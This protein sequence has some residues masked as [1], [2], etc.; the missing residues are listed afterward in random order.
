VKLCLVTDRRRLVPS[1]TSIGEARRCLLEQARYAVE[2]RMDLIQL[3]ERDLSSADLTSLAKELLAITRGSETRVVINDRIDVALVCRADGVHLR[4]DS[5]TV[6]EARR[7]VPASFLIGRSIHG[8]S[9]ATAAADAD[10]LV[11]G[12]VFPSVSK[13]RVGA[14]IGL[15]G[16]EAIVRA[17]SIP[18]LAIGGVTVDRAADVGRAGASG[19]AAIGLFIGAGRQT[20]S[21]CGA[22][23]LCGL[24]DA[25][26][27][28]FDSGRAAS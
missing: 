4:G 22:V 3:R 12:T 24:A 21:V 6:G 17:V 28:Q 20:S 7:L 18:V 5:I 26:R 2:A 8:T 23:P 11:A 25:V 1:A 15:K 9:E 27:R 10:Y 19:I 16:L 13:D 14:E